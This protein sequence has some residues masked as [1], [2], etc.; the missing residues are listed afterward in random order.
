MPVSGAGINSFFVPR[1]GRLDANLTLG[2]VKDNRHIPI[3]IPKIERAHYEAE[4]VAFRHIAAAAALF[5][6]AATLHGGFGYA[7][8]EIGWGLGYPPHPATRQTDPEIL[9]LSP[10]P[11]LFFACDRQCAYQRLWWCPAPD[12]GFSGVTLRQIVRVSVAGK[13]AA[14]AISMKGSYPL[15]LAPCMSGGG[16]RRR[17]PARNRSRPSLR[18]RRSQRHHSAG[19]ALL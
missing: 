19:C 17:H 10:P 4:L 8:S 5:L 2:T 12:A 6:S 13:N 7:P 3:D 11:A 14:T 15:L 16:L 1:K 18:W 9:R